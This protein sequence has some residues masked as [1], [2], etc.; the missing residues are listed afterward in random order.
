MDWI[1]S[2]I[3]NVLPLNRDVNKK[4]NRNNTLVCVLG[5][6]CAKIFF[7]I[8]A[9]LI[10]K[11]IAYTSSYKADIINQLSFPR[12]WEPRGEATEPVLKQNVELYP[13]SGCGK[14]L[15]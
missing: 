11:Y 10:I 14:D 4:F 8:V 6:P 2:T 15:Q 3:R 9:G 1:F 7:Y 12:T 5:V 13:A